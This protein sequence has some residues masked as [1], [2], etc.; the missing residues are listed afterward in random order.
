MIGG[1]F[2]LFAPTNDAFK[3]IPEAVFTKLMA[4][5]GDLQKVLLGHVIPDCYFLAG[6]MNNQRLTAMNGETRR[7]VI[8]G[9][10]I[11][12]LIHYWSWCMI[13]LFP[14]MIF[15][16]DRWWSWRID[17]QSKLGQHVCRQ[18]SSFDDRPSPNAILTCRPD[19]KCLKK[20]HYSF[21]FNCYFMMWLCVSIWYPPN[22]L[23]SMLY[24][25]LADY[26]ATV[27]M[28]LTKHICYSR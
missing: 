7:I 25:C 14:F 10:S 4:S 20:I 2:T 8:V 13:Y 28:T 17:R 1:P 6:L 9:N 24:K 27:T 18:R 12:Y 22:L 3:A 5:P 16:S 21:D 26:L 11:I 19:K 23:K 15:S